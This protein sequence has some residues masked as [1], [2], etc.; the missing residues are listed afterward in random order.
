MASKD[1]SH[2]VQLA[3]LSDDPEALS[4]EEADANFLKLPYDVSFSPCGRF[5]VIT[6]QRPLFGLSL[7][8]H[9]LVV[10]DLGTR[11]GA[12]RAGMRACPLAAVEN[13]APRAIDWT[14]HGMW[15][16]TRHG[17]CLLHPPS[18]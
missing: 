15:I 14:A 3:G 13:V 9:A 16:L 17:A 8:S 11:Y 7:P 5:A 12:R 6:D 10:L 4:L 2:W 1:I 18:A